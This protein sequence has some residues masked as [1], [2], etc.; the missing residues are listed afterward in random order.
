MKY[1]APLSFLALASAASALST[2]A[3]ARNP[4]PVIKVMANGMNLLKP[5]FAAEAKIQAS[6][7]GSSV[8]TDDVAKEIAAEIKS[9]K[10]VI[11]TYGLSPFSSEALAILDSTGVDYT[12]IELGAEW[13]LLDEK[14]SVKRVALSEQVDSGATSL[15]KVF[16]NGK[17]IGGCA[18]LAQAVESGEFASL[19]SSP[20]NKFFSFL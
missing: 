19:T 6:I 7:L 1:T 13:F 4:N 14:D 11:Y 5:A 10:V 2:E 9:N 12:P 17:C 16:V 3:P 18:E 8:N 15:P 20:K